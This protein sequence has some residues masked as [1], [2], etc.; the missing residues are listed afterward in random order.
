MKKAFIYIVTA[1]ILGSCVY[2][3]DQQIEGSPEDLL[4]LDGDIIVGGSSSVKI[5]QVSPLSLKKYPSVRNVSGV[6]WIE[7][8][9]GGVYES[10]DP[11]PAS[12]FEIP[13]ENASSDRKY[14]MVA[15]V[16]GRVYSS[17]W[18]DPLE[19]PVIEDVS[20]DLNERLTG[21]EVRVTLSGGESGTGYVG[22]SFDETWEFHAD[23]ICWYDYING[24][25]Q[26]RST[27]Y[28][29]YW[30]W[31]NKPSEG[32]MLVD[33]S[34]MT[35]DVIQ[36]YLIKS[37]SR[38]DNRL[39]KKYS[40][41]VKAV[42]LPEETYRYLKNLQDITQGSGSLFSPNPGEMASN[43]RCETD[44][45]ERVFGYVTASKTSS[46]RVFIGNNY[47]LRPEMSLA[48]I[49]IPEP[50]NFKDV[51][52]SGSRP[53]DYMTL[54]RGEMGQDLSGVYWGPLRCI[55]CIVAGGTKEKPDFW[56]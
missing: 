52:D 54:P 10:P 49:F 32:M 34:E 35:S 50:G 8:D 53:I 36:S 51:Y 22:I 4:V 20:I 38:S 43:I 40:I 14:R 55:D 18:I 3:Y 11:G 21:V 56:E 7:D 28:P 16:K 19:P 42:T 23:F 13:M 27:Q 1:I 37:F 15:K 29:N 48:S 9:Q 45:S 33:Y 41:N 46:C 17:D 24:R 5:S 31:M 47:Y 25:V 44:P 12:A 6:A 39:H 26:K 30:C 2:P